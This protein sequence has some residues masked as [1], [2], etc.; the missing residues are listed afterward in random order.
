LPRGIALK[1]VTPQVIPPAPEP[2]KPKLL[3]QVRE[4]IRFKHY[5]L[6]TEK[7]YVDWI[8]R[9]ILYHGKRHPQSMGPA[10]VRRFLGD[11]AV[12]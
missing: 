10:E 9:F 2:R 3:D 6:R 1:G 8:K 5:S 4:A 7:T 11:L 12:K